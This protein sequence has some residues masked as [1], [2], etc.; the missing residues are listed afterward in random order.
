MEEMFKLA[1][2][3]NNGSDSLVLSN[4]QNV[5]SMKEMFCGAKAF[6]Q[7]INF[8]SMQAVVDMIDFFKVCGAVAQI[9]MLLTQ[10]NYNAFLANIDAQILTLQTDVSFTGVTGNGAGIDPT[11][12]L[13]YGSLTTVPPG[14]TIN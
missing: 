11:L 12:S 6:N 10:A 3:F 13:S 5:T 14:W 4:T 1:I 8:Q 9:D 2:R 7:E